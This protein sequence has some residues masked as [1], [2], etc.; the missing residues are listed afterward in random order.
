MSTITIKRGDTLLVKGV[1]KQNDGSIMN[2]TGYTI[3]VNILNGATERPVITLVSGTTTANRGV[4]ITNI[5]GGEFVVT[6]KDTEV[7]RNE[8]YWVDF[9]AVGANGYEQTSKALK[10]KVKN[11]LV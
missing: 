1:Y 11:K 7:L 8:E 6:M 3:E 4:V 10:L 5:T 2:L 9:K